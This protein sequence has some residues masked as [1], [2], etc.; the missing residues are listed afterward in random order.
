M[1]SIEELN[2]F[3][4]SIRTE[5]WVIDKKIPI[6]LIFVVALQ[7]LG[8]TWGAATLSNE[9]K[10]NENSIEKLEIDSRMISN[11]LED[12]SQIFQT[13]EV[14]NRNFDAMREDLLQIKSRLLVIEREVPITK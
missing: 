12:R 1:A 3:D 8:F 11:K 9:V 10:N 6:A 7:T 2:E 14:S 13:I 4:T 5:R